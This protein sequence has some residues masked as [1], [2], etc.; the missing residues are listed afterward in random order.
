MSKTV[1]VTMGQIATR[2][3]VSQATVSLVLNNV[4]TIKLAHSTRE[5]VLRIAR[6]MGYVQKNTILPPRQ[7]KIALI[8]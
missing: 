4:Q 1:N 7:E 8:V 6:E 2:A 3:G 5:K